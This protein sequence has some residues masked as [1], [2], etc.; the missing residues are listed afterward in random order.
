MQAESARWLT[1]LLDLGDLLFLFLHHSRRTEMNVFLAS[2]IPGHRPTTVYWDP[3]HQSRLD[4]TLIDMGVAPTDENRALLAAA[5]RYHSGNAV[6]THIM[7][8]LADPAAFIGTCKDHLSQ[9]G[10]DEAVFHAVT[11]GM[12]PSNRASASIPVDEVCFANS[13]FPSPRRSWSEGSHR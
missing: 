8:T 11:T 7:P 6:G 5:V 10:K 2:V 12:M 13:S 3:S 9:L 1:S 4:F